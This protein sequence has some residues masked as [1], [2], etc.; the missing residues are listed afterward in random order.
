MLPVPDGGADPAGAGPGRAPAGG[1][2]RLCPLQ[3]GDA[4]NQPTP[5]PQA[6]EKHWLV[7]G[8]FVF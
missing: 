6:G 2:A 8:E 3:G 4:Q 7:L 1:R 5:F